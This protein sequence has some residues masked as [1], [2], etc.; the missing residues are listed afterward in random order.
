MRWL[1]LVATFPLRVLLGLL[2]GA[3]VFL[4]GLLSQGGRDDGDAEWGRKKALGKNHP[5][6]HLYRGVR[7]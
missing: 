5:T 2:A 3:A 7:P 4:V 6:S 1:W